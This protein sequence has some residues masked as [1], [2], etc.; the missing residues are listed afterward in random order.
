MK[1][2]TARKK[3]LQA[4]FQTDV[5]QTE[6][7]EALSNVVNDTEV[8]EFLQN[9]FYGVIE[10]RDEIDELISGNLENWKFERLGNVDRAILRIATYEMKFMEDIP[11]NVSM[12]E[13]IELAKTFGDDDSSK[14]INAV[15]SKVK[16]KL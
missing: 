13:A 3:T 5:G 1:R 10:K 11:V 2:R 16:A 8:D 14:F 6:P 7:K 9:L 12:D 15:L 4:L